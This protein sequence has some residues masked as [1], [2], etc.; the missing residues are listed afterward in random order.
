MKKLLFIFSIVSAIN[1][2]FSQENQEAAKKLPAVQLKDMNGNP[3]NTA[4]LGLKGPI[5]ISFW[6]TWCAPCKRELNTIHELY[7]DWQAATGVTLV[8]VSIDDEKTKNQVPVYV[9]G[10]M[11]EYLVLMDP[12]GDFKRAMGVN[13]VPHTFLV[14]QNGNIVYSHNNYAPGDEEKLYQKILEL[15]S[16]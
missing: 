9:N 15:K 10:K 12:N 7:E 11:W 3:V 16:H 1:F 14:D 6:A 5:V 8:A 2:S 4:E 13:N